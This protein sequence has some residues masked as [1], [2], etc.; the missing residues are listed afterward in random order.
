MLQTQRASVGDPPPIIPSPLIRNCSLELT[1]NTHYLVMQ[2]GEARI[3]VRNQTE[4]CNVL[5]SEGGRGIL[6]LY[7]QPRQCNSLK[8]L[9]DVEKLC[10]FVTVIRRMPYKLIC[11][12]K[13]KN[14]L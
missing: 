4:P 9:S 13:Q 5:D 7:S 2:S 6:Y 3:D 11:P 1:R 14:S 10:L 12:P 8:F